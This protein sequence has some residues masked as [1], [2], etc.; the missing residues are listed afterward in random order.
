MKTNRLE[1]KEENSNQVRNYLPNAYIEQKSGNFQCKY[2]GRTMVF[3]KDTKIALLSYR[4]S[5]Q[6]FN[7][8]KYETAVE[9]LD[10][11]YDKLYKKAS[12]VKGKTVVAFVKHQD[13][14]GLETSLFVQIHLFGVKGDYLYN[15]LARTH[16]DISSDEKGDTQ[17]EI[18][19]ATIGLDNHL[20]NMV[21][22]KRG[23]NVYASR[24]FNQYKVQEEQGQGE[25][26]AD[27]INTLDNED[28]SNAIDRFCPDEDS[29]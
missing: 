20:V 9:G 11:S 4:D 25:L 7:S 2:N 3:N 27:I 8:G 21:E 12:S 14:E 26:F 1:V 17:V 28:F 13:K 6:V 19:Y 22:T 16:I 5:V 23:Y 29:K 10:D 15:M 18:A 24:K